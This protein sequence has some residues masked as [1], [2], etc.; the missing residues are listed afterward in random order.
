MLNIPELPPLKG[1]II[2]NVGLEN[3]EI[4]IP[5]KRATIILNDKDGEFIESSVVVEGEPCECFLSK[6]RY[7]IILET[8]QEEDKEVKIKKDFKRTIPKLTKKE[9]IPP[10]AK[11]VIAV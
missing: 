4:F 2:R 6:N 8:L 10:I 1:F 3:W 11:K 7:K 9:L 5:E